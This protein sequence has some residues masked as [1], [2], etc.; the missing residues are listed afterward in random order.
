MPLGSYLTPQPQALATTHPL[1]ISV[2]LPFPECYINRI[3]QW[4]NLWGSPPFCL[5]IFIAE[6]IAF[7]GRALVHIY[8]SGKGHLLLS[9]FWPL[10][11]KLLSM[12][13]CRFLCEHRL[14]FCLG[15][16]LEHFK[17]D[18]FVFLLLSFEYSSHTLCTS[19]LS[20]LTCKYFPP[21]CSVSS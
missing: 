6:T 12:L 15:K 18:L 13:T 3:M 10:Q 7:Y 4:V 16:S 19:P 5:F 1:F 8:S 14:S 20:D 11:R 17:L 2:V 9:S 21:V